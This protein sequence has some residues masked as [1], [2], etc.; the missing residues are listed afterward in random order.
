M[1]LLLAT[2][3]MSRRHHHRQPVANRNTRLLCCEVGVLTKGLHH[4]HGRYRPPHYHRRPLNQG[5]LASSLF[6]CSPS[7]PSLFTGYDLFSFS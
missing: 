5:L 6:S 1:L 7:L 3:Y 4:C 2:S